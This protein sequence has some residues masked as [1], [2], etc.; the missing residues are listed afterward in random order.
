MS[1]RDGDDAFLAS[2]QTSHALPDFAMA[3]V[4]VHFFFVVEGLRVCYL[5]FESISNQC[6]LLGLE[7]QRS[8]CLRHDLEWK[9]IAYLLLPQLAI[10]VVPIKLTFEP[11]LPY[12][13]WSSPSYASVE[14]NDLSKS[15]TGPSSIGRLD[16]TRIWFELITH[17][18]FLARYS[19]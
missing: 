8:R 18:S 7:S 3:V 9:E 12:P 16:P 1:P 19:K 10:L 13:L 4:R 17:V 5:R 6:G 14:T 15:T 11:R 2:C